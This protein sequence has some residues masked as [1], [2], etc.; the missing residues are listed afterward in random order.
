MKGSIKVD[1]ALVEIKKYGL[2]NNEQDE[3][4]NELVEI[5][6]ILCDVPI[7]LVT[8]TDQD[9]QY[10]VAR[11]GLDMDS[12]ALED[13]FCK[14]TLDSTDPLFT[15]KNAHVDQRFKNNRYVTGEP[16]VQFYTGASLITPNGTKIGTICLLDYRERELSGKE[17]KT[18][19]LTAKRVVKILERR[20]QL[21]AQSKQI[22]IGQK[23][24]RYLTDNAPGALFQLDYHHNENRYTFS[25]VSAGISQ[26]HPALSPKHLKDDPFLLSDLV[27]EEDKASFQN[28]IGA[29]IRD[30]NPWNKEFRL[31]DN[32]GSSW[33]RGVAV[34]RRYE[35][36]TEWYGIFE[37]INYLKEYQLT[38]EGIAFDISHGLR[39]PVSN[40]LGLVDVFENG[41][42]SKV[43]NANFK[44]YVKE[45]S[46]EMEK[47]TQ[48]LN[49]TYSQK[50]MD[51]Q[52]RIAQIKPVQ[53]DDS[54]ES[55]A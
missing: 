13:S 47:F 8:L 35:N 22:E 19:E 18:I 4:L 39:R 14:Y 37:N 40:L 27:H 28:S 16:K 31:V 32:D 30:F 29:A 17:S 33:M 23:R 15:V 21:I 45:V 42:M 48:Q 24:L 52:K 12:V 20:K 26:L 10:F 49:Q 7:A 38:L 9:R 25:F 2:L 5:L 51:L 11:K 46:Q 34:P 36:T 50:Q 3:E 44:I 54:V 41:Q 43:D 1:Q 53:N 55:N 6:S